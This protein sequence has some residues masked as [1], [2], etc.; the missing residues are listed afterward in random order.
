MCRL[1]LRT[2]VFIYLPTFYERPFFPGQ[3]VSCELCSVVPIIGSIFTILEI[4]PSLWAAPS[5]HYLS[6]LCLLCPNRVP[7]LFPQSSTV[8]RALTSVTQAV[9]I[10]SCFFSQNSII[11]DTV[12]GQR[13]VL[14]DQ[15]EMKGSQAL[16]GWDE[17]ASNGV[18]HLRRY[19]TRLMNDR[20]T[21]A[22]KKEKHW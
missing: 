4:A 1:W 13:E 14:E 2:C 19:S 16:K 15:S 6:W 7:L 9:R 21:P 12:R 8:F 18:Q 22:K 20:R 10:R 5:K 17:T 3:Y 11:P